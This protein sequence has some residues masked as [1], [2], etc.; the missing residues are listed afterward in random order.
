MFVVIVHFVA[1][2]LAVSSLLELFTMMKVALTLFLGLFASSTATVLTP[3]NWDESV[4]GKTVFIKFFAPW[5][6][7]CKK[8]KPDWDKLMEE[9]EGHATA[10]IGDCDCTAEC[11]PKCDENGVRGFPTLK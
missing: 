3:D 6:G 4:Q 11:K 1:K 9:Y 10:L 5:C 2:L 8:M 7:H